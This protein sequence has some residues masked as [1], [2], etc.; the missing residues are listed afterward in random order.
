MRPSSRAWLDGSVRSLNGV[1]WQMLAAGPLP[2]VLREVLPQLRPGEKLKC[3]QK[4]LSAGMAHWPGRS[5][6]SNSTN[7]PDDISV[8]VLA[9]Y[10]L[11]TGQIVDV[12]PG[13][14]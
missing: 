9:F 2:A 1:G 4:G 10:S 12:R 3:Y 14:V 13:P 8:A 7:R 5:V 11:V 6:L